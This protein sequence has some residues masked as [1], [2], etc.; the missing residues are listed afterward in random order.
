LADLANYADAIAGL[1]YESAWKDD[2]VKILS[3]LQEKG[4]L[5]KR[6]LN[7]YLPKLLQYAK[8]EVRKSKLSDMRRMEAAKNTDDDDN[9]NEVTFTSSL[10]LRSTVSADRE[11]GSSLFLPVCKLLLPFKNSDAAVQ[12][13]FEKIWQLDS[14]NNL[15]RNFLLYSLKKK[16]DFPDTVPR[17]YL[18]NETKAYS[19][20]KDAYRDSVDL[21][22][23]YHISNEDLSRYMLLK[24]NAAGSRNFIDSFVL[25][26]TE[27]F[28]QQDSIQ[29]IFFY[30]TFLKKD[31]KSAAWTICKITRSRWSN[32]YIF[33]DF[34]KAST[35][36]STLNPVIGAA[37]K[38]QLYL[39]ILYDEYRPVNR[40]F[41]NVKGYINF[42][43]SYP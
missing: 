32:R 36:Y 37:D 6:S 43:I 22:N 10:F 4:L 9:D 5:K 38:E 18:S 14:S 8:K 28:I 15:R 1:L 34:L 12:D 23:A 13:F 17:Q 29:S 24:D 25:V 39:R 7:K 20:I 42:T 40:F 27:T 33:R 41:N 26:K 2:A 11:T 35:S 16:L 31:K 19:F 3:L 30:K 21:C